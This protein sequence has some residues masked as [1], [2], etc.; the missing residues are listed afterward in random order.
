M[1][2]VES[3]Q[4]FGF[5]LQSALGIFAI[6]VFAWLLSENRHA[7]P[8]RIAILGIALQAGIAL[9]LLKV[10]IAR[11]ALFASMAWWAY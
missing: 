2:F 11:D 6:L 9:L 4:P 3:L 1:A 5:H 8:W 7:F 10:E